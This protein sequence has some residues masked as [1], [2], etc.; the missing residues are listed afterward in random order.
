MGKPRAA[1]P[2]GDPT[3]Q[4]L[5]NR[6]MFAHLPVCLQ[7]RVTQSLTYAKV[8][9]GTR[10]G[11]VAHALDEVGALGHRDGSTGVQEVED[12][13]ALESVV[14][15]GKRQVQPIESLAFILVGVEEREEHLRTGGLEGVGTH[16]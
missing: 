14:V 1:Q 12:V 11:V 2:F 9:L 7:Q 16:L 4:T 8:S 15:S 5:Q 6:R 13:G 10:S 3:A